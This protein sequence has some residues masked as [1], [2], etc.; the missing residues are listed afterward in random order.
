MPPK[1]TNVIES[2]KTRQHSARNSNPHNIV[3]E[4]EEQ[5]KRY[6]VLSRCKI[7]PSRYMCE[8]TLT[9]LGLKYEVDRMFHVIGLLEFMNFK[10]STFERI[11]LEFLST[12]DFQLQRKWLGNMR[13]YFGTLK[14]V[15]F[16]ENHE[17]TVEELGNILKLPIYGPNDVPN[18]FPVKHFWSQIIGSPRQGSATANASMIQKPC[19]RYAQKGLAHTLF[20][21]GD[22]TGIATQRELFFLHAIANNAIINVV[23]FTT[24]YLGRVARAPTGGISMG[25]M[26]TQIAQHLRYSLNLSSN[27]PVVGKAKIDMESLIHQGMIAVTNDS[28]SLMSCGQFVLELPAHSIVSIIGR[29]NWLYASAIPE[30]EDINNMDD[31]IAGNT[32]E[33]DATF[34]PQ[35]VPPSQEPT[36]QG[37]GSFSMS[38]DQWIWM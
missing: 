26:I 23:A 27:T 17:L 36:Q 2:F 18:D 14:F 4:D 10:A 32:M 5:A 21:R 15:I 38:Q 7:T 8:Q 1:R 33:E 9:D 16:N 30:E 28:S 31:F 3:F 12:L 11:T 29:S 24:N 37:P 20:G 22:S 6:S 35:F 13:Y 19:F 34:Q 25:G